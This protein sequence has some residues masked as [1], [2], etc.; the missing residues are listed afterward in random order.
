MGISVNKMEKNVER[1]GQKRGW[2]SCLR[3]YACR[4][5]TLLK[6]VFVRYFGSGK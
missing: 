3:Y 1:K 5:M 6:M 2:C 4:K